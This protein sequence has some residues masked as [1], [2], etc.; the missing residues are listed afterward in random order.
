MV[1]CAALGIQALDG[2]GQRRMWVDR[3]KWGI[4]V[5]W[6]ICIFLGGMV[7]QQSWLLKRHHWD[8]MRMSGR[9]WRVLF[10]NPDIRVLAADIGGR[11][12][13]CATA[14][15][16]H[17]IHPMYLLNYGLEIADG[18]VQLYPG[19]YQQFW[20]QV[21]E[22]VCA[23]DDA[24]RVFFRWGCRVYLFHSSRDEDACLSVLPFNQWY[25]LNLLSLANVKYLVSRNPVR[26]ERL[27]LRTPVISDDTRNAWV[28]LTWGEKLL[29][30]M[31]G[32][33][34]PGP[35]LYIYEN[36]QAFDRFFLVG[37]AKMFNTL[38]E[39][40]RAL[41]KAPVE[42]LATTAFLFSEDVQA[43]LPKS[44]RAGSSDVSILS[45]EPYRIDMRVRAGAN[46]LL[47]GSQLYYTWWKC[48]IDGVE[49]GVIPCDGPFLAV[50]VL[51]GEHRVVLSYEPPYPDV[52]GMFSWRNAKT[53]S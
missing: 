43:N 35:K 44:L 28:R 31:R 30:T 24:L 2:M 46:M 6:I 13:R 11:P 8:E 51:A 41:S 37:K 50:P 26:D 15:A 23:V 39:L 4:P 49:T 21:I 33:Q 5:S 12:V 40:Y 45:Y 42:E 25:N 16:S 47:V 34:P 14:G 7:L 10:D 9:T 3:L 20:A 38:D 27:V 17:L 53:D 52:A 1:A 48:R 32:E 18:Y 29:R 36:K 19:R 22:P